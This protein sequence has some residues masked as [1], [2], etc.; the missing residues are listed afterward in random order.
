MARGGAGMTA[1]EKTAATPR[2]APPPPHV[3]RRPAGG[4]SLWLRRQWQRRRSGT[5]TGPPPRGRTT[6]NVPPRT[7][8]RSRSSWTASL[9]ARSP[10]PAAPTS[11]AAAARATGPAGATRVAT[12][13]AAPG[14]RTGGGE[15]CTGSSRRRGSSAGSGITARPKGPTCTSGGAERAETTASS[16]ATS[17]TAMGT[18]RST[19][20][21]V[22]SRLPVR[23]PSPPFYWRG[24]GAEHPKKSLFQYQRGF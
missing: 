9:T 24:G 16:R 21:L 14:P 11:A 15:T 1:G 12:P 22:Q 23:P 13:R 10:G 3:G 5:G 17:K 20:V 7:R 4:A 8:A 6:P 19:E 2:G 18:Q